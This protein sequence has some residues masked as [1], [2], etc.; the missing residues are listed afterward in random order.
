MSL[1][2]KTVSTKYPFSNW[3]T[4]PSAIKQSDIPYKTWTEIMPIK[5][6]GHEKE[7]N[8]LISHFKLPDCGVLEDISLVHLRREDKCFINGPEQTVRSKPYHKWSKSK[9]LKN[10]GCIYADHRKPTYYHY[11]VY[12]WEKAIW[13]YQNKENKFSRIKK[14]ENWV[15]NY[16]YNKAIHS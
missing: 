3:R 4:F 8:I 10:P 16:L 14:T 13:E 1:P 2:S 15:S 12:E 6:K 9:K 11:Q 7:P 5:H